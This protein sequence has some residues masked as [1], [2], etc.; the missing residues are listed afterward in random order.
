MKQ[1]V[2]CWLFS[3][4]YKK[5]LW[6]PHSETYDRV[7]EVSNWRGALV[8]HVGKNGDGYNRRRM[9][10]CFKILGVDFD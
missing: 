6:N 2:L 1:K 8:E 5:W 9:W 4:V 3:K 10:P 7:I